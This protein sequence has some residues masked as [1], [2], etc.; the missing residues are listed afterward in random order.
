MPSPERVMAREAALRAAQLVLQKKAQNLALL[1]VGDITYLTDF[2]LICTGTSDIQVQA[3][4][5]HLKDNFKQEGYQL[6]RLE[7]YRDARWVLL[8]Y[9]DLVV[10]VFQPEERD[11]YNLERLW[12][13]A[14]RVEEVGAIQ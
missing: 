7:G 14:P 11:F 8:D 13:G 4:T 3:I 2:F 5:D 9:G 1:E 12:D 10:H 6:L